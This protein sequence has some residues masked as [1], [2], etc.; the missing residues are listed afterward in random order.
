MTSTPNRLNKSTAADLLGI[1]RKTIQ[2]KVNNGAL[3][4]D[5]NGGVCIEELK[6]LLQKE[7]SKRKRGPK[8]PFINPVTDN[9]D[10]PIFSFE[11]TI[12]ASLKKI[13]A[14]E[15]T[16]LEAAE[17]DA[18]EMFESEWNEYGNYK[19][20]TIKI[21]KITWNFKSLAVN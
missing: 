7:A 17:A 5:E 6:T 2:R 20:K 13:I 16:S 15:A 18:H 21:K 11:V 12:E 10:D 14:L 4:E 9:E 3:N 8:M 1:S 19:Q